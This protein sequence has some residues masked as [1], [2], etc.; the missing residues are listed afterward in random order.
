MRDGEGREGVY[1]CLVRGHSHELAAFLLGTNDYPRSDPAWSLAFPQV[2][3]GLGDH[4]V[5]PPPR[6]LQCPAQVA[7][8][9]FVAWTDDLHWT[10]CHEFLS[11][12]KVLII[13]KYCVSSDRILP[14]LGRYCFGSEG[15]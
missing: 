6:L 5:H 3:A 4:L 9:V 13:P 15:R 14:D 10:T 2:E 1:K 7:Q 8:W 12:L 11:A